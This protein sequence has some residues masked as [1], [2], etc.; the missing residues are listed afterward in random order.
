MFVESVN[1]FLWGSILPLLLLGTGIYLTIRSG[2]FQIRKFGLM[3]RMTL[4]RVFQ[5]VGAE[6]KSGLSAWETVS[7]ALASTLGTGSIIGIALAIKAGGPGAVFWMWISAFFGMIT[8]YS[9]I[10]LSVHYRTKNE[11]GFFVGGPMYYLQNG[12][13][14]K[15]LSLSFAVL[16]LCTCFGIGNT[17]QANAVSAVICNQIGLNPKLIGFV[18][19]A[20][21]GLVVLGGVKRVAAI[22]AR[23]VPFMSIVYISCC[24]IILILR[25][26]FIPKIIASIFKEAFTIPALGGGFSSYGFFLAMKHGFSKGIF[27]NEAGLGSAPI[28][29]S[30]SSSEDPTEQGMWGMF[31]VF[32]TTIIICTL[33]ALVVLCCDVHSFQHM[34][35]SEIALF[36]FRSVLLRAG[37]FCI[38]LSIILFSISTILGW[39]FYGE[40]CL[41]FLLKNRKQFLWL[42]RFSF[43]IASYYGCIGEMEQ[44]WSYSE[45]INALM[46][47]P[48]LIGVLF[49][50]EQVMRI[51]KKCFEKNV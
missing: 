3:F 10:V 14:S 45:L 27:S 43:V 9:E 17:I 42:F 7:T 40:I 48:N 24:I 25:I 18:L 26:N 23:L 4:G 34:D 35:G 28:A 16:C 36:A 5:S 13:G 20:L 2:F 8:K 37:G 22:N 6:N 30:S 46:A 15:L 44:I 38:C 39:A 12:L 19:S 41:S 21:V 49:L 47:I 33:T 29:H 1:S 32:F 51:S 11:K 50:S 31:E